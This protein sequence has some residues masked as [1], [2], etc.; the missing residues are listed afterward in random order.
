MYC[1]YSNGILTTYPGER[2]EVIYILPDEHGA[3][4]IQTYE[5]KIIKGRLCMKGTVGSFEGYLIKNKMEGKN[6]DNQ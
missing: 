4:K 5:G 2:R 1:E 3:Y 6:Y